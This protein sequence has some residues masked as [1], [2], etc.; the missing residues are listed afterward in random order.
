MRR[1]AFKRKAVNALS[2]T[3]RRLA[4]IARDPETAPVAGGAVAVAVI[5]GIMGGPA[6]AIVGLGAG[7]VFGTV[8]AAER[9]DD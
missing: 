4:Q 2:K 1:K 3:G 8:F 5:G 6:G 7:A 9:T